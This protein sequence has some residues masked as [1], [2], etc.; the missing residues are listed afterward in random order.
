MSYKIEDEKKENITSA[1]LEV[2]IERINQL[3]KN[4]LKLVKVEISIAEDLMSGFLTNYI[5]DVNKIVFTDHS[6][7][8]EIDFPHSQEEGF[9]YLVLKNRDFKVSTEITNY[10]LDNTIYFSITTITPNDLE[11]T[12]GFYLKKPESEL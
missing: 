5:K 11:Y 6:N 1:D 4:G 2:F 7:F 12:I 3:R 8:V 10:K 9:S